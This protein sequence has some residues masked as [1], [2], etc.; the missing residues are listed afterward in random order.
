MVTFISDYFTKLQ[1]VILIV[2]IIVLSY[3]VFKYV[4]RSW[5]PSN[6]F[7][8]RGYELIVGESCCKFELRTYEYKYQP[9]DNVGANGNISNASL[10][11]VP[12]PP[13]TE[14]VV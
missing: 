1:V 5:S 9:D 13:W 3:F 6:T 11:K 8:F 2:T 14:T 10:L 7:T 12:T 4:C